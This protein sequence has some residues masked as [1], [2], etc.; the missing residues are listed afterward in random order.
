MKSADI[1]TSSGGLAGR[2]RTFDRRLYASIAIVAAAV[3][4]VG[5]AP[6]FYLRKW[7]DVPPLSALRYLHGALMT[8][9][10]ALFLAQVAL[11]SRRRVD[12]HRRLGIFTALTAVAILPVGVATSIAFIHRLGVNSD[13]A[14]VAAII[15]GYDFVSL[16]VFALLVGTALALRRR[17][18][19][20]KR[21]MTLASL[22]LLGPAFARVVPDQ[23]ALWLTYV[24]VLIPIAID[25]WRHRRLHP[26]FAWGGALFL[27]SSRIALH[28]ALSK[29][30]IDFALR[31]FA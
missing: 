29:A 11:V 24:V 26:A 19:V 31:T 10:Y 17:S 15:A 3:V 1:A 21:L 13:E 20:H 2:A 7:F 8:T 30:W 27:I 9:W 18:D 25:T 16:L 5:F 22:S 4:L 14:P 28:V 6:T 12:I 23:Q